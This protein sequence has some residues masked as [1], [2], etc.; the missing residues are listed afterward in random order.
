[1]EVEGMR[2]ASYDVCFAVRE[3]DGRMGLLLI[4]VCVGSGDSKMGG[5]ERIS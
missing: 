5:I 3:F 2:D 1:M 4:E